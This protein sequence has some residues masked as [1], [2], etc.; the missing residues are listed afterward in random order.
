M[1]SRT[2]ELSVMPTTLD[3]PPADAQ[4]RGVGAAAGQRRAGEDDHVGTVLLDAALRA[5]QQCGALVGLIGLFGALFVWENGMA[6]ETLSL[7]GRDASD[8]FEGPTTP[9]LEWPTWIVYSAIPLGS[10]LMCFRFLQ[11]TWNFLHTGEL[12]HHDHG[13]VDGLSDDAVAAKA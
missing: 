10:Y 6:Y 4:P 12:P 5:G 9:D 11:V 1:G 8:F 7:F 3:V 13:H 2:S